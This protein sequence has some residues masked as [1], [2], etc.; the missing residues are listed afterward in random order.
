MVVKGDK[1][2]TEIELLKL[3]GENRNSS[4]IDE[5]IQSI[6][7][8]Y[9]FDEIDESC[10]YEFKKS[11]FGLKFEENKLVAIF[12]YG[13]KEEGFD[14]YKGE[15]PLEVKFGWSREKVRKQLGQPSKSGHAKAF[16]NVLKESFWDRYDFNEFLMHITYSSV[17]CLSI[18]QIT[19]MPSQII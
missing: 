13:C 15:I 17:D 8:S 11:G 4:I 14:I 5:F 10:S 6:G 16:K 18:K 7:K 12:L 9:E 19:L 1:V 3:L 2:M